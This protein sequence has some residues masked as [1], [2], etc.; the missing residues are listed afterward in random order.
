MTTISEN[1]KL[2]HAVMYFLIACI[3]AALMTSCS[4]YASQVTVT[5]T[6]TAS[7]SVTATATAQPAKVQATPRPS[8]R[9]SGQTVYLRK[10]AGM[11][12]AVITVL[13]AGEVLQIRERGAWLRVSTGKATGFI[14]GRYCQ[15]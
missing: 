15:E 7:P 13:R 6:V 8:C 5:E 1:R 10:G 14:F 4:P 12:Y 2:F 3:L 11:S 9:V